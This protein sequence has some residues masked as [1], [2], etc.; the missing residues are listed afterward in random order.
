MTSIIDD[1]SAA[2]Q[3]YYNYRTHAA[4]AEAY[5][6][7]AGYNISRAQAFAHAYVS[8]MITL[9]HSAVEALMLGN[10]REA[11]TTFDYYTGRG[12]DYRTDTFRDLY[13]N[14]VGIE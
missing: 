9:E 10:G 14:A 8:A 5:I 13:N 2:V 11:M 3:N 4:T 1:V 12:D 7:Q 6:V